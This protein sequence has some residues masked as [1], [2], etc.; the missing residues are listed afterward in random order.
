M[1]SNIAPTLTA[2]PEFKLILQNS[3]QEKELRLQSSLILKFLRRELHNDNVRFTVEV[4][5]TKV[6]KIAYSPQEKFDVMVRKNPN[7]LEFARTFDF[8]LT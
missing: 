6:E 5:E 7:I 8:Q 2:M 4:D 3:Y 1:L